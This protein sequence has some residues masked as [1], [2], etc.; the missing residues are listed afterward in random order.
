[1]LHGS[2]PTFSGRHSRNK[3]TVVT[4]Y[5][6]GKICAPKTSQLES[7]KKGSLPDNCRYDRTLRVALTIRLATSMY[8]IS[9][10]AVAAALRPQQRLNHLISSSIPSLRSKAVA[11]LAPS[12]THC[13]VI[14]ARI[15]CTRHA[16]Q[17]IC[18]VLQALGKLAF[19]IQILLQQ[20]LW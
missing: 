7:I 19:L 12:Y 11:S 13:L 8:L 18:G 10:R 17:G 9:R 16:H 2:V 15:R 3:S 5:R 6:I 14:A 4:V 1:M 20:T